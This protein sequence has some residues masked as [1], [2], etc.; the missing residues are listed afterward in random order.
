MRASLHRRTSKR[1]GQREFATLAHRMILLLRGAPGVGKSTVA[2]LVAGGATPRSAVVEV[3]DL[4]GELWHAG[5]DVAALPDFAR[6]RLA[7]VMAAQI[8]RALLASGVARVVV[9]DTFAAAGVDAF[10]AALRGRAEVRSVTLTVRRDE[11]ARRLAERRE[12]PGVFRDLEIAADMN[13]ELATADPSHVDTT[14]RT[15][16]DVAA[17]VLAAL[18]P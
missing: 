13:E 16:G 8:A 1:N 2:R 6:H 9:A 7:L 5:D 15:A 11:H 10:V 12:V 4:R 3:D 17:D 14:E 18:C